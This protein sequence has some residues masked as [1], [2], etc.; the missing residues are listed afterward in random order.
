V[1]LNKYF[2]D[3][4]CIAELKAVPIDLEASPTS[5]RPISFLQAAS[6]RIKA[7]QIQKGKKENVN[8]TS[9]PDD[10]DIEM[11][12]IIRENEVTKQRV[13][14]KFYE[15]YTNAVRRTVTVSHFL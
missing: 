6:N 3:L 12:G 7:K 8:P 2:V 4:L 9:P 11:S 15:G 10:L 13:Y 14:F 5:K 1:L